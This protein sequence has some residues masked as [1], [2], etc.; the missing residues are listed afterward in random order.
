M[1]HALLFA[2]VTAASLAGCGGDCSEDLV[3]FDT[4]DT[5]PEIARGVEAVY[6]EAARREGWEGSVTLD[7]VVDADGSVCSVDIAESSGRDDVDDSALSAAKDL[8]FEPGLVG[9]EP[10]RTRIQSRFIFQLI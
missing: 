3:P 5:R 10:V 7:I 1:R 9:G 4:L 2:L 8:V 6:P